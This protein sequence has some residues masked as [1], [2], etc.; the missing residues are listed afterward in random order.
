MAK[1]IETIQFG[2]P[3][4]ARALLGSTI[5][6]QTTA[7]VQSE[8]LA[9]RFRDEGARAAKTLKD[10]E[11]A[12]PDIAKDPRA[13]AAIEVDIFDQQTEDLKA[14]GLD[15]ARIRPDGL[16]PTPGDIAE[17][18]R[19]YRAQGMNVR[20]PATMLENATKSFLD[21]KGVATKPAAD[22][23]P[24]PTTKVAPVVELTVDRANRRAAVPQ[25][26]S[27]TAAP[28]PT[29][30]PAAQPR[31][32]SSIVESMKRTRSLARGQVLGT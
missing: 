7:A 31:D 19:Y 30:Q 12:N 22:P 18:H 9:Q 2:D 1:L 4:E 11:D 16:P 27:R 10:F 14:I 23:T 13:R 15:P 26:P 8:L 6:Q 17:A 32:R 3:E 5:A 25:Q 29:P 20:S 28:R 24:A 21:W